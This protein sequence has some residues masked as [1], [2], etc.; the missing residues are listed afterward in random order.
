MSQHYF[1]TIA[2]IAPLIT[3]E[4]TVFMGW[5]KPLQGYFLVI[6]KVSSVSDEPIWSNLYH[7]P[8]H[9]KKLDFFLSILLNDYKIKLPQ[10]M[11]NELIDDHKVN[12]GNKEVHHTFTNGDYDRVEISK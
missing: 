5:D 10:Q 3:A 11:I 4:V 6:D 2:T 9:P 1:C 7:E 12:A 8:S